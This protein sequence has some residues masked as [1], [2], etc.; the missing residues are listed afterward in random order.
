MTYHGGVWSTI[1]LLLTLALPLLLNT[2]LR[3]QE[4]TRTFPETGKTVRG[5]F[6]RYWNEHGGLAQQGYPI[7]DEMNLAST[8]GKE[9][10]TQFFQRAVFEHHPEYAGTENEVLLKLVG[11]TFYERHFKD[12]PPAGQAVN[13]TNTYAFKETG[14][15]IG[16][17]SAPIGRSTAASPS[18]ATP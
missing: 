10:R 15:A 13:P 9:Y 3:A 16:A 11:Q 18:R 14:H 6:L 1:M 7:T 5:I 4:T 8:D 2:P 12:N 17:S